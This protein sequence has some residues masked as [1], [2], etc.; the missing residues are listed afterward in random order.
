[1][2]W[3]SSDDQASSSSLSFAHN[4]I[5]QAQAIV[6]ADPDEL[7]VAVLEAIR[8]K[9]RVHSGGEFCSTVAELGSK[10]ASEGLDFSVSQKTVK[11]KQIQVLTADPNCQWSPEDVSSSQQWDWQAA[12]QFLDTVPPGYWTTPGDLAAAAGKPGGAQAAGSALS[13]GYTARHQAGESQPAALH[14]VLGNGGSTSKSWLPD[15]AAGRFDPVESLGIIGMELCESSED[16]SE[17]WSGV[18]EINLVAPEN[19]IS[20]ELLSARIRAFLVDAELETNS[21]LL[22]WVRIGELINI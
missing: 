7:R 13:R 22:Y 19:N 5:I 4:Y 21:N 9:T 17:L 20:P 11:G 6:G 10:L 16:Q 18:A 2:K 14:R 1:M 3:N 12:E 15:N 8:Q